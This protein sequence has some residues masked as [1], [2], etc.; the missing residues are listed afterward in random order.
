M[1][2]FEDVRPRSLAP[3]ISIR[4]A[5]PETENKK[6]RISRK[7][8]EDKAPLFYTKPIFKTK[9]YDFL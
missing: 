2:D 4:S 1:Q 3:V 5:Q 8:R 6:T 9:K 7:S